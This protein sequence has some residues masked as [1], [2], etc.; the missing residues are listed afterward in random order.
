MLTLTD[1]EKCYSQIKWDIERNLRYGNVART[2]RLMDTY[3]G[4][5]QLINDRFR[6]DDIE[7]WMV[8]LAE[9]QLSIVTC[10]ADKDSKRIVFYDQIGSTV[11]LGLQY[12][13]GLIANGY[14]VLYIFESPIYKVNS[15]LL[16]ELENNH[17]R[18][19]VYN[20][21]IKN[22]NKLLAL[23]RKIQQEIVDFNPA[24]L[25][26]HAPAF[27]A[28][29]CVV[30]YSL[31]GVVRYRIVPGDHHFYLGC[32]CTDYFFEFRNFGIKVAVE[33]RHIDKKQLFKLPYYPIVDRFVEFQGF[34][35]GVEGKICFAAAGAPYKFYG[36]HWFFDFAKWLLTTYNQAVLL[37]IGYG[38][39]SVRAFIVRE[40]LEG[41][42]IPVGFRKDFVSCIQHVDVL[43]NS[44]P[45]GGGLVCQTAAYLKKPIISYSEEKELLN[46]SMR[47]V[48]G[49]EEV[50]TPVSFT[51]E[52]ALRKYVDRLITNASFRTV[53]GERIHAM[54][55]TKERFDAQLGGMLD[56]TLLPQVSVTNKSCNVEERLHTY[57]DL[58]NRFRPSILIPLVRCYGWRLPFKFSALSSFIWANRSFFMRRVCVEWIKH[59]PKPI[60]D[61]LRKKYQKSL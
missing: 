2:I 35:A 24:R 43:I 41:R 1:I 31:R 18:Y 13:R 15:N 10:T 22:N 44:Y 45:Y 56:S 16:A 53:E 47:A 8:E 57:I 51:D 32:G 59:F 38:D 19:L 61:A 52:A 12:I 42:F 17:I 48:L 58:Q 26:V 11:C 14:E 34:P 6:D 20:S 27:G 36:S 4:V 49:A 21:D 7:H 30:L 28:L 60:Q 50:G 5:A 33:Q 3:A 23:A 46:R 55:Q 39:S 37:F 25:I 40:H 9:T 54:L 29:G